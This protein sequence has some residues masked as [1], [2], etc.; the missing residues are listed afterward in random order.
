M[1]L[2][3]LLPHYFHIN[4]RRAVPVIDAAAACMIGFFPLDMPVLLSL[5]PIFFA[6][7]IQWSS[8]PGACGFVSST[9]FSTNNIK[10]AALA[11]S[12]FLC[13]KEKIHFRKVRFFLFTIL[14]FHVGAAI[15]FFAIQLFSSQSSFLVLPFA[16]WSFY[17]VCCEEQYETESKQLSLKASSNARHTK[18]VNSIS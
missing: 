5:Y 6:M 4:M 8:F 17:L 12:N 3:T 16:A 18:H 15:S 7:S 14:C 11:F 13:D 2:T 1:G 9:I 10:Q